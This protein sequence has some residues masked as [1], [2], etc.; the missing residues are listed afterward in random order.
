MLYKIEYISTLALALK[1]SEV[2]AFANTMS[3]IGP[4]AEMEPSI[5]DNYSLDDISRGIGETMGMPARWLR[6]RDQVRAIREARRE[7]EQRMAALQVA[8]GVAEAIPKLQKKTEKGSPL[9]ALVGA[10]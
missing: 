1:F 5:L 3:Y 6:P 7:A 9:E 8:Q 2:K 10:A 4:W